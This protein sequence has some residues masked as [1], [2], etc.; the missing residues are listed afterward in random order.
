M[1]SPKRKTDRKTRL[2]RSSNITERAISFSICWYAPV[3]PEIGLSKTPKEKS[4]L[5]LV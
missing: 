3:F 5:D 1:D 2:K 4:M